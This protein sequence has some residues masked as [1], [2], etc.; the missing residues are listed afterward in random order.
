MNMTGEEI[1]LFI[2]ALFFCYLAGLQIGK[3]IRMIKELGNSA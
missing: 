1:S 2:C 3:V